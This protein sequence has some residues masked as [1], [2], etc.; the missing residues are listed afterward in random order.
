MLSEQKRGMN[1]YRFRRESYVY[2]YNFIIIGCQFNKIS[3][4]EEK[5]PYDHQA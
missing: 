3:D 1:N 5:N 4:E 2:S